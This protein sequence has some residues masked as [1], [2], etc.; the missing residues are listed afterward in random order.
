MVSLASY[1]TLYITAIRMAG[2][3][4]LEHI[5]AVRFDGGYSGDEESSVGDVI[6][7]LGRTDV[8]AYVRRP[9]G[10]RGPEVLVDHHEGQPRLCSR[11]DDS[12]GLDCLLTLPRWE[13]GR[14]TRR[15]THRRRTIP[16]R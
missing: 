12:Q 6:R 9:G 8:R 7:W 4:G 16:W 11:V 3:D 10:D 2:G 14:T 13:V 15:P 5:V 1:S